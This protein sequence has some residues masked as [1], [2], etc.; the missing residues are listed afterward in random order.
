VAEHIHF[1][2]FVGITMGN[3]RIAYLYRCIYSNC[4]KE[5]QFFAGV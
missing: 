3:K 1:Y 2:K 5:K 4:K